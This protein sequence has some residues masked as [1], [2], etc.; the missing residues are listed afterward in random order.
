M[1]LFFSLILIA[2][3]AASLDSF[4]SKTPIFFIKLLSSLSFNLAF[5]AYKISEFSEKI[6]TLPIAKISFLLVL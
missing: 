3:L 5:F 2:E 4:E 1:R 6:I